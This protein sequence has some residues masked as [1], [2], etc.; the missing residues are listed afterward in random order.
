MANILWAILSLPVV[1]MPAATAGLFA[2][3]SARARGK[4]PNFFHVFFEGMRL[5][6]YKASL[7]A[8]LDV[9][10]GALIVFNT[11]ILAQMDV[12]GDPL[13]FLARSVTLFT[14]LALLL[15][16]IYAWHLLIL[17]EQLTVR[18]IVSSSA[19]LVLAYPLW[20]GSVLVAAFV[21]LLISL[22]LPQ[23]IFVIATVSL[24]VWI[25]CRG[26]WQI[27]RQHLTGESE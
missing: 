5:H 14:A 22:L 9:L 17:M 21:P 23:G 20:S 24:V 6:W 12:N 13:A 18:Q 3:M 19:R 1:T 7:I 8:L 11:L 10:L 25:I 4:H 2:F 27:I 15:I 26:T 16:N